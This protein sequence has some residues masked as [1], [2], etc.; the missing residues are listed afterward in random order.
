MLG[1]RIADNSR[2]DSVATRLRRKRFELLRRM[3][4]RCSGPVRILDVGGRLS[5]WKM[6]TS[7]RGFGTK[8]HVTLLNVSAPQVD[9]PGFLSVSGDGRS[10][11]QFVD[12]EFDIVFSNSTIEHVGTYE[13]QRRMAD[14]IRRI[15]RAY[16]V[17]TPNRYFPVE[18][19]F[20]FPLFQFLP[21]DVRVWL[22]QHFALG[23]YP[24]LPDIE[25]ARREVGSIELLGRRAFHSLFPEAE[26]HEERYLGLVKS[27]VAVHSGPN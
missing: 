8:V 25:A 7:D 10:M 1:K 19:H 14:E 11:P 17:Q 15:G 13:D 18:P 20:L 9:E 22:V 16:Y 2:D 3:I 24:R 6:M 21:I 26:I 4:D 5:Y 27:F 12:R 23:W